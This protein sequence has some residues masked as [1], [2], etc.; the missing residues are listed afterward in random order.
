MVSAKRYHEETWLRDQYIRN[1]RSAKDIADDCDVDEATIHRWLNEFDISKKLKSNPWQSQDV[2]E[3]LYYDREMSTHEIAEHF[4]C[5]QSTI[6]YWMDKFGLERRNRSGSYERKPWHNPQTLLK[7]Y[8]EEGLS[9]PEIGEKF[10][11]A[12]KT[13]CKWL[14]RFGVTT[15]NQRRQEAKRREDPPWRDRT[16]LEKLYVEQ[17]MSAVEIAEEF[18]C[19]KSTILYWMRKFGIER[20]STSESLE[21]PPVKKAR[22]EE[23]YFEDDLTQDDIAEEVGCSVPTVCRWMAQYGIQPGAVSG[24]D[25]P[26]WNGGKTPYGKGFTAKKKSEVR[27]RDGHQCQSCSMGQSEHLE[28]Y[29]RKLHVHHI[30]PRRLFEDA[31]KANAKE[32][33][34]TLCIQC[35]HEWEKIAP[36]RPVTSTLEASG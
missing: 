19:K 29:D 15:A 25:H 21:I 17:T 10:G 28:Q 4:D 32:N 16:K 14:N 35:H 12:G 1:G 7:L 27:S 8:F 24:S 34:V 31:E 3:E 33:L 9:P 26:D 13:I 20:R 6:G 36:L 23:L 2:L 30:M 5:D 22:L 11:C 18:D